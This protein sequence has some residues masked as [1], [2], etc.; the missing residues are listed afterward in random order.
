MS[1][2][3]PYNPGLGGR[4]VWLL[5]ADSAAE[6]PTGLPGAPGFA[7][8]VAADDTLRAALGELCGDEA[9][10]VVSDPTGITTP[11]GSMLVA[12]PQDYVEAVLRGLM[13]MPKAIARFVIL[14]GQPTVVQLLDDRAVLQHLN[15]GRALDRAPS[16]D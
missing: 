12:G 9:I 14:P 10:D 5:A 1:S 13:G 2:L 8:V 4:V 15:P 16:V 11:H 3:P 6:L 7:Q